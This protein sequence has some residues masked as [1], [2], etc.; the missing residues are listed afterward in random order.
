MTDKMDEI[1]SPWNSLEIAKLLVSIV[2]PLVVVIMGFW[3]QS[4]IAEQN[5]AYKARER[6]ADRR[7]AI[8]EQVSGQLN[9]IYCFIEDV[10]TWKEESPESIIK[11]K[12]HLDNVMYTNQ[13]IWSPSTF[14]AYLDYMDAAFATYQGV[15]ID[16]KIR[17]SIYQKEKGIFG[18]T[19]KWKQCLTDEIDVSHR[20]KYKE[21][22]DRIASDLE[23]KNT[24]I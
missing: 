13:A 20:S 22:M 3:I 5:H 7:L 18:W 19:D 10:G 24:S 17:T 4:T 15:G 9:R 1:K 16:A 8:Y 12:R 6:L 11:F 23:L 21:L 14:K 2:T